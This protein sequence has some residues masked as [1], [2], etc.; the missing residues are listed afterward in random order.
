MVSFGDPDDATV[1][2]LSLN[3]SWREF[4]SPSGDW[5]LG[6]KRRL[7]SLMSLG[8]ADPRGLDDTQVA[9][10]VAGSTSYFRR[11]GDAPTPGWYAYL[12]KPVPT[13]RELR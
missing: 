8:A 9:Q 10:V 7:A 3:P 5:L 6:Q 4:Q 13:P 12:R 11:T 2:T 1:A